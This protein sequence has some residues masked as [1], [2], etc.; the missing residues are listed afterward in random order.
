MWN[1]LECWRVKSVGV[2]K[3]LKGHKLKGQ[4]FTL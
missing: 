4:A 3:V 2:L 1:M